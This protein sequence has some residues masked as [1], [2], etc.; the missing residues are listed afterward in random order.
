MRYRRK[1]K[2]AVRIDAIVI[3]MEREKKM[4]DE[5]NNSF[6]C[7]IVVGAFFVAGLMFGAEVSAADQNP[8]SEDIAKFCKDV[9]ARSAGHHGVSGAS[10]NP[11][12]PT[13]AKIM[14]R[15]WKDPGQSREK[16]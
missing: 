14:K 4:K 15:R 11:N 5:R 13:L 2:S 7:I 3:R 8:C 12:Y 6:S 9:E 1:N 10:M 16:R